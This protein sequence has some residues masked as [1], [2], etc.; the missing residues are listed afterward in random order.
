MSNDSVIGPS[1]QILVQRRFWISSDSP[2]FPRSGLKLT[3]GLGKLEELQ[4]NERPDPRGWVSIGQDVVSAVGSPAFARAQIGP[5]TCPG[6]APK[7]SHPRPRGCGIGIGGAVI[8]LP[9]A[10][11]EPATVLPRP[12]VSQPLQPAA[13]LCSLILLWLAK[14]KSGPHVLIAEL[15]NERVPPTK[16]KSHSA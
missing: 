3:W 10:P 7:Q 16:K 6:L 4:T 12:F 8:A 13:S 2:A 1:S 5:F 9:Q 11:L 15:Q 14:N